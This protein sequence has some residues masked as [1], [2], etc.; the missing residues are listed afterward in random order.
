M[1]IRAR[2]LTLVSLSVGLIEGAP[3]RRAGI[4]LGGHVTWRN[5]EV[6][7]KGGNLMSNFRGDLR[8]WRGAIPLAAREVGRQRALAAMISL[9]DRKIERLHWERLE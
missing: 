6:H 8:K 4:G 3:H 2:L 1:R 5:R 7:A 9:D